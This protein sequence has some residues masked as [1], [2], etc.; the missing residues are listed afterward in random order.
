MHQPLIV[1]CTIPQPAANHSDAS[2]RTFTSSP[3][4]LSPDSLFSYNHTSPPSSTDSSHISEKCLESISP[5]LRGYIQQPPLIIGDRVLVG[6]AKRH[7]TIAYIGPTHF[8]AGNWAGVVLDTDKGRHDGATHGLRYFSCPPKRGLFCLL[9]ALERIKTVKY[10]FGSHDVKCYKM[11]TCYARPKQRRPTNLA[12]RYGVPFIRKSFRCDQKT[13][14]DRNQTS[15]MQQTNVVNEVTYL[16]NCS[17][18]RRPAKSQIPFTVRG[19]PLKLLPTS[20]SSDVIVASACLSAKPC[21]MPQE[22]FEFLPAGPTPRVDLDISCSFEA[23]YASL[24]IRMCRRW[25][26]TSSLMPIS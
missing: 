23:H 26:T 1:D 12:T 17:S 14:C 6:P 10:C 13:G 2:V 11:V 5:E 22:K 20:D 21:Q 7:G 8:A 18:P 4:N 16:D 15:S 25:P 19:M 3:T 24:Y 9:D